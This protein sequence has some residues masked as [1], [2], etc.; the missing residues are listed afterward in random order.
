MP[1]EARISSIWRKQKLFVALFLM[2]IG[3]WFFLDGLWV[4]PRSNERFTEHKRFED[5]GNLIKWPEYAASRGWVAEPPHKFYKREDLIGQY[6]FGG[7][8]VL[9]GLVVFVYWLGQKNRILR[10]DEEAV[11][12]PAGVRVP[13]GAITG[14]G[15]KRWESKGIAVVRY[16][17]EGRKGQFIVDDYKYETEPTRKILEEIEEKVRAR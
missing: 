8:G 14:I 9:L 2:A 10:N 13:Y 11:H 17:I 16:E 15:K 3:A 1:A 4:W 12:T 5:E 6:A 7:L